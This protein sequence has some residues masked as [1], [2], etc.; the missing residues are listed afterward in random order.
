MLRYLTISKEC[1]S[2]LLCR[3]PPPIP[4]SY[5]WL[6]TYFSFFATADEKTQTHV[7]IQH[8]LLHNTLQA[9]QSALKKENVVPGRRREGEGGTPAANWLLERVTVRAMSINIQMHNRHNKHTHARM[10]ANSN[11]MKDSYL[12]RHT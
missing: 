1:I 3:S 8:T 2:L 11:L 12:L 7:Q 10:H 5:C 9:L 6:L 4:R